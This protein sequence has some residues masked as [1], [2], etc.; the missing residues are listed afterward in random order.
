[1]TSKPIV[2]AISHLVKWFAVN[3][4]TK[5]GF[6]KYLDTKGIWSYKI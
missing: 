1:V 3:E 4:V 2:D 5:L 6:Y